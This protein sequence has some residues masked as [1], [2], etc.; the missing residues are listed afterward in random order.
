MM[1]MPNT[2]N[3]DLVTCAEV[4]IGDLGAWAAALAAAGAPPRPDLRLSMQEVADF[5]AV[6]WHTATEQL[7][8]VVA[9]SSTTMLWMDP[10]TVELQLTAERRYDSTPDPQP[11]LDDYIDLHTL[12]HSD[13]GQLREMAVTITAPQRPEQPDRRNQT[14][15]ALVFMAHQF[16]FLEV[17]I[18]CL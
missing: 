18:D 17:D 7:A 3:S 4:R 1:A 12:G 16:G 11:M 14:R 6:A 9:A 10:P 5:F 15:E 13:R 2:M 8:A